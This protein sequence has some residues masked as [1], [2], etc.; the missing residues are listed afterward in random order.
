MVLERCNLSYVYAHLKVV[1]T[2]LI[3]LLLCFI[4]G[5]WILA[6][7]YLLIWVDKIPLGIFYARTGI[8]AIF[9]IEFTTLAAIVVGLNYSL[10]MGFL[11]MS[12]VPLGVNSIRQFMMPTDVTDV[13]FILPSFKNLLDGA[14]AVVAYFMKGC[15]LFWI[16]VV[17]HIVKM[18]LSV[19]F[20]RISSPEGIPQARLF[21]QTVFNLALA[22]YLKEWAMFN[23]V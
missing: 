22:V 9:Y 15:G 16:M 12:L 18:P 10:W 17:V 14:A 11:F 4:L 8:D 6:F 21:F 23:P 20:D 13:S 2:L 1:L 19:W 5:G 3:G 7:A